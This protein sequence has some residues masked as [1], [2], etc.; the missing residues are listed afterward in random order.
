MIRSRLFSL[1][2][3]A[4][5]AVLASTAP[6]FAHVA[7]DATGA[8]KGA[9]VA[10]LSFRV[11][12]ES[13]SVSTTKVEVFFP[14][15][16]PFALVRVLAQAP[17]RHASEN[18][19]LPTPIKTDDGDTVTEAVSKITWE[20]GKIGPGEFA[21]FTVEVGPL[22]AV[23][24]LTFKAVQTYSD[25][26]VVRWIEDTPAGGKEPEYPAPTLELTAAAA[27]E[28]SAAPGAEGEARPVPK[29][30]A[31]TPARGSQTT[32]AAKLAVT[33]T[34]SNLARTGGSKKPLAIAGLALAIGGLALLGRWRR[35]QGASGPTMP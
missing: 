13:D 5:V 8:A 21:E 11:P 34:G 26:K 10:R 31:S 18:Q 30:E 16:H 9:E 20:G 4:G 25:G 1:L 17:W 27:P 23:D 22:P 2:A 7:I 28:E 14:I 12:N 15:D 32:P 29:V 19:K 3:V 33:A 24:Q 6:A 35:R